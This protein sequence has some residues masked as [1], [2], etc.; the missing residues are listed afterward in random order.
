MSAPDRFASVA[1]DL[2][3]RDETIEQ[4]RMLRAPGLKVFGRFFAFA[5]REDIVIKLSAAR[6]Q[7]LIASGAG[8]PCAIRN[9][10]P[11]REWVR[12]RPDC[13]PECAAYLGEAR[14]FVANPKRR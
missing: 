8:E 2:T 4:G 11:I 13:D 12:L 6:V 1:A 7:E 14:D 10:A 5:T 3:G 9:V